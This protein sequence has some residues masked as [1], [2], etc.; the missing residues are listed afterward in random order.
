MKTC[1]DC[2]GIHYETLPDKTLDYDNPRCMLLGNIT[3]SM[4]HQ[5]C[6][7]FEQ[8]PLITI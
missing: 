7:N 3:T 8:R 5:A 2:S 4:S 1:R 6:E